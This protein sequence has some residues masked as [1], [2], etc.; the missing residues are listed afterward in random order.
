MDA[1]LTKTSLFL[2][3]SPSLWEEM[4]LN[5]ESEL[6][7]NVDVFINLYNF[8]QIILILVDFSPDP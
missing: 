6:N 3:F 1:K 4:Q 2:F 8:H 5:M 7:C